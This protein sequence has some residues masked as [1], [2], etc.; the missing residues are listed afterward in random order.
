MPVPTFALTK[1]ALTAPLTEA[2]SPEITPY[3][4]GVP[5]KVTAVVPL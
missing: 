5:L 3:A 2:V 1:F 4:V